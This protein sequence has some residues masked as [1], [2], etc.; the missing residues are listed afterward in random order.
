[1]K[2]MILDDVELDPLIR[3]AICDRLEGWELI[4][5]LG[6]DIETVVDVFEEEIL[7]NL[8]DVIELIT[9]GE[10]ETDETE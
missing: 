10:T 1:M 7:E 4:D 3:S 8:E 2:E 5:F 6:I 9:Y